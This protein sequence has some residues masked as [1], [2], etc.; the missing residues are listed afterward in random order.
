M[1]T[2]KK[3]KESKERKNSINRMGAYNPVEYIAS[4]CREA[5]IIVLDPKNEKIK[6][7]GD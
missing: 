1:N 7:K 2:M 6:R 4:K 5:K 3:Y